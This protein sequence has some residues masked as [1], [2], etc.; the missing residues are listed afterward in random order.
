MDV[1]VKCLAGSHLFGTNT[2]QSD[3]DYKGIYLPETKD[4]LLGKAKNSLNL[5][6]NKTNEKNT[7][8]DIDVEFYSLQKYMNMLAEGQTVALELLWTPEHMIIEKSPLWDE[9]VSHRYELTHK[10]VTAFVGYCRTQANKYGVK[11]SRMGSLKKVITH[12]GPAPKHLKLKDVWSGLEYLHSL[13]H[14]EFTEA[15]ANK[16]SEEMIKMIEVCGRKF[17]ETVKVG[18][19]L[20]TMEKLYDNYGA[21]AKKAELNEGIDWKALSHAYRV[22]TQ[23][24]ELLDTG[25]LTLPLPK[26]ALKI[27]RQIKLGEINFKKVAP[28]LEAKVEQV[29]EMEAESHLQSELDY[30]K[31]C[32]DFVVNKYLEKID[33]ELFDT[34]PLNSVTHSRICG[35]FPFTG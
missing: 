26:D 15:S 18:Y 12:L 8:E 7:S 24:I 6:S 29:V 13:D 9:I 16:D 2:P 22:C 28:M 21:R 25:K 5:G 17:H 11:G 30:K 10:K 23:A 1:V 4:I 3:K 19:A 27:V 34:D 20:E 14:V 32:E 31:W 33:G 35:R